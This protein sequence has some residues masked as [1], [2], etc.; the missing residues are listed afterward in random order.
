MLVQ[1]DCDSQWDSKAPS[2]RSGTTRPGVTHPGRSGPTQTPAA[3]RKG[4]RASR[5]HFAPGTVL[6]QHSP[7]IIKGRVA[8][9]LAIMCSHSTCAVAVELLHISWLGRSL[10]VARGRTAAHFHCT[11]LVAGQAHCQWL[12]ANRELFASWNP[13]A[14]PPGSRFDLVCYGRNPIV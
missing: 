12:W 7:I 8:Q 9:P 10:P 4:V 2:R 5:R 6:R 3:G 1:G 11:L 14:R 13:L